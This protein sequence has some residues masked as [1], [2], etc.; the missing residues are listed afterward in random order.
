MSKNNLIIE[1]FHK[2][3]DQHFHDI[4]KGSE[5]PLKYAA[6]NIEC[7]VNGKK[8]KVDVSRHRVL[9]QVLREELG[10]TGTKFGC[11]EGQCGACTVL[12]NG[13]AV[14]SCIYPASQIPGN[15]IITIEG[16]AENEKLHPV[17]EAFIKE[18][19][20]QCGYC[21]PGMIL[22]TVDLL[23]ENSNPSDNEIIDKMNGNICR[24]NNYLNIIAAVRRSARN[25]K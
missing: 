15:H 8:S 2:N 24:C 5:S 10:L 9:L 18:G 7:T 6:D 3:P 25:I 4:S 11:G 21:V 1:K 14:R 23:S 17:Q 19:A 12:I 13:R 20:M 16:L 22:A